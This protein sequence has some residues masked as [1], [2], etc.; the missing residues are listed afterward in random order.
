MIQENERR[1][2]RR[3]LSNHSARVVLKNTSP[4][5]TC[6]VEEMSVGGARLRFADA[7]DLPQEFVL[8]IP[9]LTLR[10]DARLAWSRGEHRGVRFIWPQ[11]MK[12]G[13]AGPRT[14]PPSSGS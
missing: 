12:Y 5:L 8:E 10:V 14:G 6:F 13:V 2:Y 9:S 7:L 11:Q 3:T 4:A 1:W